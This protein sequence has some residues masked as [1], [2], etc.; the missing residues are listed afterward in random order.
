MRRV[1]Y[2]ESPLV[3]LFTLSSSSEDSIK[4][5]DP[6][7]PLF[8]AVKCSRPPGLLT[9][10]QAAGSADSLRGRGRAFAPG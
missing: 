6:L 4:A 9:P 1:R 8:N 7:R 2:S 3:H 10:R 5:V